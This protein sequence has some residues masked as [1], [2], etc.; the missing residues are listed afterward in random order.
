[1]FLAAAVE[2]HARRDAALFRVVMSRPKVMIR[3]RSG[4]TPA[5]FPSAPIQPLR[6][7]RDRRRLRRQAQKPS[8]Q[9]MRAVSHTAS[10]AC[11]L[12][13]LRRGCDKRGGESLIYF[14][15]VGLF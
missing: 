9:V 2:S 12:R 7:S 8:V 10:S 14:C 4:Q 13:P 6:R 15:G 3:W 1:M 5:V 11:T